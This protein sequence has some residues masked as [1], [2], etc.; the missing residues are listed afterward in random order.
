[1]TNNEPRLVNLEYEV[2]VRLLQTKNGKRRA[3]KNVKLCLSYH[4]DA[5]RE[6]LRLARKMIPKYEYGD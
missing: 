1:M 3:I 2:E 4:R 5:K 6:F